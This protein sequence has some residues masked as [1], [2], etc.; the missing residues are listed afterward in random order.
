MQNKKRPIL[1]NKRVF[2]V[3]D[4]NGFALFNSALCLQG[5]S[6]EIGAHIIVVATNS[7]LASSNLKK[8]VL[9]SNVFGLLNN[10]KP[11]DVIV[12]F[13]LGLQV[14]FSPVFRVRNIKTIYMYHEPCKLNERIAKTGKI[15]HGVVAHI[16]INILLKIVSEAVVL[17]P[18]RAKQLGYRQVQFPVLFTDTIRTSCLNFPHLVFLGG[19]LKSRSVDLFRIV[20]DLLP[21]RLPGFQATFFPNGGDKSEVEKCRVLGQGRVVI[22]NLFTIEYNQSGVTLDGLMY[23]LPVLVNSTD[24]HA[25]KIHDA[26]PYCVFDIRN[27]TV[28][29]VVL[30]LR[31]IYENYDFYRSNMRKVGGD[32]LTK[33]SLIRSWMFITD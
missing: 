30:A 2:L 17:N 13:S 12:F 3:I 11:G 16:L 6:N 20:K 23:G 10:A 32:L 15:L 25:G 7:L 5:I 26:C 19:Q 1:C 24:M 27:I 21:S 28:E 33:E 31:S 9:E 4:N 29:S 14:L 8:N 22:W 18:R